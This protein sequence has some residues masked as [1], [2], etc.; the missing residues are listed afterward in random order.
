MDS[1][2]EIPH[3]M[4]SFKDAIDIM[5]DIDCDKYIER[6]FKDHK[7]KTETVS[8]LMAVISSIMADQEYIYDIAAEFI[9]DFSCRNVSKKVYRNFSS[10]RTSRK[11]LSERFGGVNKL[12]TFFPRK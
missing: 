6:A 10:E 8:S 11:N 5:K 2:P 7:I 9:R 3:G 1:E 4:N 12:S